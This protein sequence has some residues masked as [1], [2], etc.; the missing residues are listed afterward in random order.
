MFLQVLSILFLLVGLVTVYLAPLIVRKCNL[1]E[2][3]SCECESSMS[4]EDLLEYKNSKAVINVKIFGM[5]IALPGV[6]LVIIAFK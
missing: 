1:A 3:V 2:K 5:L 6:I 4:E